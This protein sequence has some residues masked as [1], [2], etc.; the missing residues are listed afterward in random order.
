[1]KQQKPKHL[2]RGRKEELFPI[3][4]KNKTGENTENL[5]KEQIDEL[6]TGRQPESIRP[7]PWD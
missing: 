1:M 7:V 4:Q 5:K 3:N 2:V 6:R